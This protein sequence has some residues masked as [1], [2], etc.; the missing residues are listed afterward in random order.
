MKQ[1]ETLTG[2]SLADPRDK[3]MLQLGLLAVEP[4]TRDHLG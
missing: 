2:R 1:I 3:L 4:E